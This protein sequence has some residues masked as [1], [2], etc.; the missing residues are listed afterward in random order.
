MLTT[1]ETLTGRAWRDGDRT[2]VVLVSCFRLADAEARLTSGSDPGLSEAAFSAK[3]KG[4]ADVILLGLG[5]AAKGVRRR[6][7]V[8]VARGDELLWGKVRV[9][10]GVEGEPMWSG[11]HGQDN[12][13]EGWPAEAPS[14]GDLDAAQL[15]PRDQR[16]PFLRGGEQLL[17]V[18][19]GRQ[20]MWR[21][22]AAAPS[23]VAAGGTVLVPVVGDTLVIDFERRI[24]IVVWRGHID[25]PRQPEL[26]A[27]WLPRVAMEEVT[28]MPL[29]WRATAARPK[30]P[31]PQVLH[32]GPLATAAVPFDDQRATVVAK[33]TFDITDDGVVFSAQPPSLTGE[34]PPTGAPTHPSDVVPFKEGVDVLVSGHVVGRDGASVATARLRLHTVD[35]SVVAIGPRQW[36]ASGHPTEAGPVDRVPL[37]YASAFGGPSFAANPVG[38]GHLAGPPPQLEDPDRLLKHR[39]DEVAPCSLGP[40]GLA[41]KV[42]QAQGDFSASGPGTGVP[43]DASPSLFNAAPP[44]Q[45]CAS[46]NG[47]EEFS[48]TSVRDDGLPLRG[49]LPGIRAVAYAAW[50]DEVAPITMKLDTVLIDAA[51]NQ[52]TMVWRST[53]PLH[54]E[55]VRLSGLWVAHSPLAVAAASYGAAAWGA[56]VGA[57]DPRFT[58]DAAEPMPTWEALERHL[59]KVATEQRR[60]RAPARPERPPAPAA[61]R[62]QVMTWLEA[63]ALTGR[64]LSRADLR[65]L[66]LRARD[67]RG[68]QLDGAQLD[69][70]QLEGANLEGVSLCGAS[71]R[72][73]N[74]TA[75]DL[76]L[77][78]MTK[79][80][81][82][83]ATLSRAVLEGAILDEATLC[84]ADLSHIRAPRLQA[85]GANLTSCRA[86]DAI[87]T[88]ADL[89]SARLHDAHLERT[90]LTD[91][92]LHDV[93]ADGLHLEGADLTQAR[94]LGARLPNLRADHVVAPG[95]NWERAVLTSTSLRQSNLKEAILNEALLDGSLLDRADLRRARMRQ[96]S[97]PEASL[98]RANLMEADLEAA[99][100]RRADLTGANLFD[101]ELRDAQTEGAVLEDARPR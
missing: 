6:I 87:L 93:E 36:S 67:L 19:I 21:L 60:L 12:A 82:S 23:V 90:T 42:M 62:A 88:R 64:D 29:S 59:Q 41:T 79:A 101:T 63:N 4:S 33:G 50:G 80:D 22:P 99:D 45:R 85:R 43:P 81:L 17:F 9:A 8:A 95:S 28:G 96:T 53:V 54:R 3:G 30:P 71:A 89:S 98:T 94:I 39:D 2:T 5:T 37:T 46:L 15:A 10:S 26:T 92:K 25:G 38:S 91:A 16:M 51:A 75:C 57:R 40:V 47:D 20:H 55:K 83:G 35:K 74:F 70:T 14:D 24:A 44:D 13:L 68:S 61:T 69:E 76:S 66:D 65:G 97:L 86:A 78:D 100:L 27:R 7:G 72:F 1:D 77:A 34:L 49:R 18:D 56:L 73:A 32:E 31:L 52:L 84:E 58:A 11:R 48:V